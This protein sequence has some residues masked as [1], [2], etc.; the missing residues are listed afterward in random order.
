MKPNA[1]WPLFGLLTVAAAGTVGA[2]PQRPPGVLAFESLTSLVGEWKG[3]QEGREVRVT[4]RLIA[5][6]TVLME[7]FR[8]ATEPMMVTMFSVDGDRLLATHYCSVGNQPQMATAPIADPRAKSLAFS[9]VRVTGMRSADDW[10]NT[11]WPS[12]WTAPID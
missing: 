4:F 12:P 1:R 2:V 9:L 8:P 7:E 5:D 11:E 10:H 6:G 3:V